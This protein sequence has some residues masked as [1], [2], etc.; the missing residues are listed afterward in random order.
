MSL[1][2]YYSQLLS[3]RHCYLISNI[4]LDSYIIHHTYSIAATMLL[5]IPDGYFLSSDAADEE[6]LKLVWTLKIVD[7]KVHLHLLATFAS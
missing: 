6:A 1:N 7:L 4:L 5:V 3:T 2:L